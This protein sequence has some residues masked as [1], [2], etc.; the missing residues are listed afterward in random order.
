MLS[1]QKI[2]AFLATANAVRSREFYATKL[3]LTCLHED[4]FAMVFDMQGTEL[5]IQKLP[6]LVTQGHTVLGWSVA[7][8][9][10]CVSEL[11]ASG[12]V[13]TT[14]QHLDQDEFGIW[15]APSGA[16]IAWFNDPDGNVLSLTQHA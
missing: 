12:V 14:Y 6:D 1:E 15:H 10:D 2:I 5:R 16:K 9:K 7:S 4:E 13:F 11:S 3:S 8:I